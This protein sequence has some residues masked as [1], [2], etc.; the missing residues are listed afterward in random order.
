V[1]LDP[2]LGILHADRPGR[3]SLACDVMEAVRP[4]VDAWVLD[5]LERRRF[6]LSDFQET[7]KGTCRVRP[8]LSHELAET[9]PSWATKVAPIAERV[10]KMLGETPGSRVVRVPTPLTQESRRAAQEWK[11]AHKN[12]RREAPRTRVPKFRCKGCGK[13]LSNKDRT[14]CNACLPAFEARQQGVLAGYGQEV[15]ARLR[16]EGKDPAHGGDAA[17][18]RGTTQSRR[19]REEWERE[20]DERPDPEIFELTILPR[21]KAVSTDSMAQATGL[22]KS[23]CRMIKRGVYTPHPRHWDALRDLSAVGP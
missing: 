13:A 23:Y 9:L 15:L 18:K 12:Q 5:L 2:A 20:H 7:P 1:G 11:G 4:A 14:Y 16:A 3:N 19:R 6:R 17:R 21:L 22:S 8:P 10:A